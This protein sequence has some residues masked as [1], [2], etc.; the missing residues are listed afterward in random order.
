MNPYAFLGFTILSLASFG[1]GYFKGASDENASL[2]LS[3]QQLLLE[4]HRNARTIEQG[5]KDKLQALDEQHT[6]ELFDAQQSVDDA[7]ASISNGTKRL[8]VRTRQA[9]CPVPD[10]TPTTGV[11]HAAGTAEL[12]RDTATRIIR[13]T[14]RGDQAIIRLTACQ[15]YIRQIVSDTQ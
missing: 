10:T 11:G 9:T 1:A 8:Y 14:E 6:Q 2:S 13:L 7:L 3:Y 4:Q 12:D 15:N 5:F